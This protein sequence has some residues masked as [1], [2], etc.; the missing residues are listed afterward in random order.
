MTSKSK[1]ATPGPGYTIAEENPSIWVYLEHN[2]AGLANVSLELLGKAR[3]LADES[4]SGLTALLIG[5]SIEDLE[6][7][8][9][10]YGVD[11]AVIIEDE[12]G[13]VCCWSGRHTMD[14]T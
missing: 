2:K 9:F 5:H 11:E 8:A 14:E 13:R 4:Q 7:Q 12:R 10:T 3:N 6:R 1:Q